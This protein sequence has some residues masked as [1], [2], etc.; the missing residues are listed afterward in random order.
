MGPS[1]LRGLDTTSSS[2]KTTTMS[3]SR[4]SFR[5]RP[6]DTSKPLTI[7][8][9]EDITDLLDDAAISRSVPMMPSGMEEEEEGEKHLQDI[10]ERKERENRKGEKEQQEGK[11]QE[12]RKELFIPIPD[13]IRVAEAYKGLYKKGYKTPRQYIHVQPFG[14]EDLPDYD[15][16]EEDQKFLDL[17]L[18]SEM[19]L[20]VDEITLE[21]MIDRLEKNSSSATDT[22]LSAREAKLLLKEEDELIVAV[23]EYWADKKRSRMGKSLMPR[24]KTDNPLEESSSSGTGGGS[25]HYVAFR[26]RPERLQ[27]RKNR[28]NDETS[29]EKMLKLRRDLARA[30]TL[31][32]MVR[33]RERTKL[34]KLKLME[35]VFGKRYQA[36][37]WEGRIVRET[38]LAMIRSRQQAERVLQPLNTNHLLQARRSPKKELTRPKKKRKLTHKQR[39]RMYK[40]SGGPEFGTEDY[41]SPAEG[42]TSSDESQ[43]EGDAVEDPFEGPFAFRRKSGCQYLA[44]ADDE[45]CFDDRESLWSWKSTNPAEAKFKYAM[46]SLS[47][48]RQ[49]FVGPVR[50]RVGR[51]GRVILDRAFPDFGWDRVDPRMYSEIPVYRPSAPAAIVPHGED[52]NRRYGNSILRK[53]IVGSLRGNATSLLLP[54]QPV[55]K[56]S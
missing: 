50:R 29:Y 6:L 43:E 32:E 40:N 18:R 39:S 42:M 24:V 38:L 36:A 47:V 28:K 4:L 12:R 9:V 26:R 2:S 15:L 54:N 44:P 37:D 45:H 3:S 52:E 16:D 1:L 8:H 20:Y 11:G 10:L 49:R 21:D 13:V 48:P 19:R 41:S 5:S 34:Q 14:S 53:D 33:R 51:G 7:Y 46:A 56:S 27:T 25:T 30:V 22:I 55:N 35:E 31:L 17:T 23:Y